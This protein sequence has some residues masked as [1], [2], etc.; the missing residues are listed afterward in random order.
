MATSERKPEIAIEELRP[1]DVERARELWQA[2]HEYNASLGSS[3]LEIAPMRSAEEAWKVRGQALRRRLVEAG[4]FGLL[5]LEG[6]ETV[7][8][9]VVRL[10]DSPGT[11]EIGERIGELTVLVVAP[12]ARGRGVGE[13]LTRECMRRLRES[14][15]EL[16]TVEV[17]SDNKGAID[18]Y[19]HAGAVETS[20]IYWL[21][22]TE[23]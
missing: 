15:I 6:E 21:P 1:E 2:L 4:A 11:W 14:G 23:D 19:E 3:R 8:L 10:V 22:L 18:F 9:A 5:A 16:M 17:L 20:R 12:Q 7:G 13:A